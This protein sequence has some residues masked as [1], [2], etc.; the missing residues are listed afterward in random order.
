MQCLAHVPLRGMHAPFNFR[1]RFQPSSPTREVDNARRAASLRSVAH[2]LDSSLRSRG[3]LAELAARAVASVV[4]LVLVVTNIVILFLVER[5][6]K[7]DYPSSAPG[8]M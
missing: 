5:F 6:I 1:R 8:K 4:A 2:R 7:S 3:E